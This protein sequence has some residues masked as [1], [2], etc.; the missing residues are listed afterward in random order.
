MKQVFM[1]LVAVVFLIMSAVSCDDGFDTERPFAT[2]V[3]PVAWQTFSTAD[4]IPMRGLL[5]DNGNLI[6]YR[7]LIEGIDSLN[8]IAK[9]TMLRR[10]IINGISGSVF[11]IDIKIPLPD[12]TFNGFYRFVLSCIDDDGNESFPDTV[13]VRMV[14]V[15]DSIPPRFQ[16][17][18]IP[19]I[20]DTLRIGMGFVLGGF[21][22][23]ETSLNFASV[24]IASM[25]GGF[26]L[27]QFEFGN[28]LD[29]MV[30]F[31]SIGWWFPVDTNWAE[32]RYR[33]YFTAWD[34]YN[35]ADHEIFFEVK[36]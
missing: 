6:Q 5:T 21:I 10:V 20:E 33:A 1:P 23:D 27:H 25:E 8:G 26:V 3:S 36:Y 9:D 14:N 29:N 2:I 18:G 11:D 35:G 7:V 24:R 34:D 19:A 31:S 12:S 22:S 30:D 16:I 4:G 17:E 28:I 13:P 32:G 15:L